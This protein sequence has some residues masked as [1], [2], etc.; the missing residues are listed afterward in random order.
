[1]MEAEHN[2]D[3]CNCNCVKTCHEIPKTRL[4][5]SVPKQVRGAI[6]KKCP[7]KWKKSKRGEA[8]V[9]AGDKKVHNSKCG[10]FDKR[11]SQE[12]CG[13][14]PLFGTFFFYCSPKVL[15]IKIS[16]L[17]PIFQLLLKVLDKQ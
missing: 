7:E 16:V 6:K 11:G 2:K 3:N 14:F 1:M 17:F 8:G 4:F 5:A 9:S 12:N 15:H 10:F 13:L